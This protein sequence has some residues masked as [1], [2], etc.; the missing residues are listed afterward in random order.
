[1]MSLL[2]ALGLLLVTLG[3]AALPLIPAIRE[4]LRPTDVEPL[5]MVGRDN[6]DIG[7]FARH[8][9]E[10]V[11]ATMAGAEGKLLRVPASPDLEPL[12][13][14]PLS[15]RDQ[16]VVL[17][18]PAE[19]DGGENFTQELWAKAEFAGGAGATYRAILGERSVSLAPRSHVLRW[20]H[21]VGILTVGEGSHLYGRTSSEREIH[22]G[23]LIGFDR[24]GAPA[25]VVGSGSPAP[26]PPMADGLTKL[27][28]GDPHD[29]RLTTHDFLRRAR[30]IGGHVRID[31][32]ADIPANFLV[33]GDLV[34]TGNLRLGPG[35]RVRGSVKTHG[36]LKLAQGVVI[37]GSLV[38]RGDLT[39]GPGGWVRGPII[40]ESALHLA[41]GTTVGST[42]TPTTV[43]GR[44]VVLSRGAVVCGH[45]V[46]EE[47][48]QTDQ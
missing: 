44:T 15:S 9:R 11:S 4:L 14:L 18:R 27:E 31:A 12:R 13:T 5:T 25:I 45:V 30:R 35:T 21:S 19:L 32:S 1:M 37:E 20:L 29:S 38:A 26:M 36:T 23:A 40:S 24:L 7:R 3:W 16:V 43:S 46:T 17:E 6:A 42:T 41:S 8:F 47:G 34:V 39:V 10:W 33:E 28:L 22:L 48:G 2:G